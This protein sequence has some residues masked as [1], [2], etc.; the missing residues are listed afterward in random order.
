MVRIVVVIS[1]L[2][3][4]GKSVKIYF[5]TRI[6]KIAEKLGVLEVLEKKKG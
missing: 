1:D 6:L 3:K 4:C 5:T 2:I